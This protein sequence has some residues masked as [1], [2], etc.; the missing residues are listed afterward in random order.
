[1]E[2][3]PE[4]R[5]QMWY[6]EVVSDEHWNPQNFRSELNKLMHM[7]LIQDYSESR[8]LLAQIWKEHIYVPDMAPDRTRGRMILFVILFRSPY[9]E[10]FGN[11]DFQKPEKTLSEM[12]TSVD[13]MLYRLENNEEPEGGSRSAYEKLRD[14]ISE[15][16]T[17]P[18]ITAG[19]VSVKLSTFQPPMLPVCLKNMPGKE[20]WTLFIKSGYVRRKAFLKKGCLSRKL[21]GE[22]DIWMHGDLYGLSRNMKGSRRGNIKICEKGG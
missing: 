18:S 22:W 19:E 16:A 3:T 12:Y 9:R 7:I 11:N 6:S 10:F 2:L 15:H 21:P 1:M 13:T 8:K 20:Y 5:K 4:L 17:D 14:Y